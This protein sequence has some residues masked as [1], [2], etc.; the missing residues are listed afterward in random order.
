M[1]IDDILLYIGIASGLGICAM[2]IPGYVRKL[3]VGSPN[4]SAK[5]LIN[6]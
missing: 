5:S 4:S 2:I 6:R 1:T 3:L